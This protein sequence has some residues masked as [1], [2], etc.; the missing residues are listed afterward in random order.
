MKLLLL[1][2]GSEREEFNEPLGIEILHSCLLK[3]KH[4]LEIYT[5]WYYQS[6]LPRKEEL[7]CYNII[8]LSL[9]SGSYRRLEK[10]MIRINEISK[11]KP[12]V[13]FGGILPTFAFSNLLELYPN[14]IC[15]RGEGE[16]SLVET[17]RC[18]LENKSLNK[19][20]FNNI[21]NL[22]FINGAKLVTTHRKLVCLNEVPKPSRIFNDFLIKVKGI[23][24]IESS[25]GCSWSRCSFCCIKEKYADNLWRPFPID[26]VAEQ[27]IELG[28]CGMLNPY[29][30]DED[31]FGNNYSRAIKLAEKIQE[32]KAYRLIPEQMK[33]FISISAKDVINPLGYKALYELKKAGLGEVFVGI[34]SGC[35]DQLKRYN[36]N[37]SADINRKALKL[38]NELDIQADLGFI[39]FDPYMNFSEL[40]INIEFLKD[41]EV[42][43]DSRLIK[44]LRIQP[45]TL[46][47][48]ECANL[49]TGRL[50]F[51]ELMYPYEFAD[52]RVRDVYKLFDEW[53]EEQITYTYSIQA[54]LRGEGATELNKENVR[55]KLLRLRS[56]DKEVFILITR[57]IG[58]EIT[59]NQYLAELS[60]Y[61]DIRKTVIQNN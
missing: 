12:L 11:D 20:N 51:D 25:R 24:R 22:A 2:L 32:L 15:I 17:V 48:K 9:N 54:E 27:L 30:T 14:V 31:F 41:I 34:E 19:E 60:E 18:Y 42:Q 55:H 36:K 57:Y 23:S 56:I 7:Q 3:L 50:N 35:D 61:K 13:I 39:M 6:G 58:K 53:E 59:S 16:I 26:Y 40:K 37:A 33:F 10:I 49:I 45:Y 8:A 21:P 52:M 46:M 38:L 43:I 1:N 29:F 44:S 4:N 5:K 47:E 28:Q